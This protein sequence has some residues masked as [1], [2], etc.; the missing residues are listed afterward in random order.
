MTP[1]ELLTK[2]MDDV[3]HRPEQIRIRDSTNLSEEELEVY[4]NFRAKQMSDS[5]SKLAK[6]VKNKPLTGLIREITK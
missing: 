6:Y 2:L 4:M 5:G 1:S 3:V